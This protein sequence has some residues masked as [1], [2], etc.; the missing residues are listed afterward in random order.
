MN[1]HAL[2]GIAF[3]VTAFCVSSEECSEYTGASDSRAINPAEDTTMTNPTFSSSRPSP[4]KVAPI[5]Y[6]GVCYQQDMESGAHGGDQPGGYLVAI[7]PA[8]GNRLWMLKIYSIGDTG[9][10]GVKPMGR[11]FRSLHLI[12]GQDVLE[13]ENEVGGKYRVDLNKRTTEWL[14]GP[15]SSHK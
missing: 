10:T 7:D 15:D 9:L 14:S 8:T 11:Y 4:P 3:A 13:I 5:E 2:L 12:T 1:A 6:K